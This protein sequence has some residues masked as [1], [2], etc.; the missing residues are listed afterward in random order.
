MVYLD[1]NAT[2]PIKLEVLNHLMQLQAEQYGNANSNYSIGWQSKA[3]LEQSQEI[4]AES[5]NT[6]VSEWQFT[7][8]ATEAIQIAF[9]GLF[10]A[11]GKAG[12]EIIVGSTEHSSVLI[13]AEGLKS[14]GATVH[15]LSVDRLG[16]YSLD[17][18]KS[19]I[20][21]NTAFVALQHSNN[22]TGTIQDINS[23]TEF[24]R[25]AN[26]PFFCDLT[27][28]VGKV[29]IDIQELNIDLACLSA[30][31]F[32]GPKGI[33]ALFIKRKSP[34]ITLSPLFN[35]NGQHKYGTAAVPL[36]SAMAKALKLAVNNSWN[37]GI[38]CSRLRTIIEQ[39]LEYAA[40]GVING[41]IRNR[42]PNT[43]NV[44][45][46]GVKPGAFINALSDYCFSQGSACQSTS[47]KASH[48]LLAM[49][50]AESTALSSFRF[51]VGIENTEEEVLKFVYAVNDLLSN[52]A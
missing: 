45:L 9:L 36:I 41:N 11:Y 24:T 40:K 13:A 17:E 34:R 52:P 46:P 27:Q 3:L 1:H 51:S 43:C 49:N 28:S 31:K 8:G 50:I 26:I 48:V 47:G 15:L 30:H 25:K 23:F 6:E 33:G 19:L 7:S 16:Q 20:N 39:G 10:R 21:A 18:F 4:F 42:L 22:E 37:Y 2:S 29:S 44:S 35:D 14:L 38:H 12:S 32:G 5:F